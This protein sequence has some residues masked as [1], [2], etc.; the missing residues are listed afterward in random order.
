MKTCKPLGKFSGIFMGHLAP[1]FPQTSRVMEREGHDPI[2]ETISV[3]APE[4]TIRQ[5]ELDGAL[6]PAGTIPLRVLRIWSGEQLYFTI[7][8]HL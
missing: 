4:R 6:Q 1:H 7:C 2:P 5:S 3:S 8:R